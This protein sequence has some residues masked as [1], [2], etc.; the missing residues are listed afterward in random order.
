[1][2]L[3]IL[4]ILCLTHIQSFSQWPL[5][6]SKKSSNS[7]KQKKQNEKEAVKYKTHYFL[8][9]K[10]KSLENLD[11]ALHQFEKCI[12][13]DKK[14]PQ[15]FYESALIN[16]SKGDLGLAEEQIKTA[17]L[18]E[19]NNKWYI[20]LYA[21]ILFNNQDFKN[22]ANEYEKL[23]K[24]EPK[25]EEF[26]YALAETY[27][28]ARAFLKAISVYDDLEE[29]IGVEKSISMQKYNLYMQMQKK[30]NAKK[31]ILK[32]NTLKSILF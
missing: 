5:N 25:N 20:L 31:E 23:I 27:V 24:I 15:P 12:K 4:I 22:A 7:Q 21:E 30:K 32:L 16:I 17:I 19:K 2:R 9:I 14:Q 29:K 10:A 26:Y 11:E 8:A 1:M 18:L 6:N 28:Y 3:A 13:L